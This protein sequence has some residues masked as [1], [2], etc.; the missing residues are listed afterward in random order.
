MNSSSLNERMGK[1]DIQSMVGLTPERELR[2]WGTFLKSVVTI[3]LTV[4]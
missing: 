1:L 4:D 3:L 2:L